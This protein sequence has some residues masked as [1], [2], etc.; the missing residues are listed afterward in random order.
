MSCML[1]VNITLSICQ[2]KQV[3][4]VQGCF[5]SMTFSVAHWSV[6]DDSFLT[7]FLTCQF[8]IALSAT[9]FTVFSVTCTNCGRA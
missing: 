3:F 5:H 4:D 6:W 1:P 2:D 8:V 7:S 9:P